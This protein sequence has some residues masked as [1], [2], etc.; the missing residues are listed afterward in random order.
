MVSAA[1]RRHEE[2]TGYPL[3]ALYSCHTAP[4]A[5]T[6]QVV[7]FMPTPF[8]QVVGYS[9]AICPHRTSCVPS[10]IPPFDSLSRCSPQRC[11]G[12]QHDSSMVEYFLTENLL[13]HFNQILQQRSNRRGDVAMQVKRHCERPSC[14]PPL[15]LE[16]EQP[17]ARIDDPWA[18]GR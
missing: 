11:R 2:N 12:D 4:H 15:L 5:A 17:L 8:C 16:A 18:P 13:A 14:A 6:E 1:T 3:A 10:L 7:N 9:R